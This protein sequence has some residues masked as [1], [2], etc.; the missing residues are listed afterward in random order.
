MAVSAASEPNA[1]SS[2]QVIN[3]S[4]T[5]GKP[6]FDLPIVLSP[7]ADR[8]SLDIGVTFNTRGGGD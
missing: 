3:N 4:S 2:S 6:S 7:V 1:A 8:G 5:T